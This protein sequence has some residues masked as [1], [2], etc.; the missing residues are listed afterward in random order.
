[1]GAAFEGLFADPEAPTDPAIAVDAIA[2]IVAMAPGTR[3]FRT[4][5]G[6]DFGVRD[7]NAALE[8][9]DAGLL[10]AL[11]MTSFAT[12]APAIDGSDGAVT[13]VFDQT[14]TSSTTFA[15]TFAASGAVSDSG[16]TEDALTITSD[17]G[18][19][20]LVGTFR[21]TV[22]GEKGTFVLTGD[23]TVDLSDLAAANVNGSWR[24]ELATG[25]YAGHTG[26]CAVSGAADLTL[27][28]PRGSVRYA[29]QLR[30]IQETTR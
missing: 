27:P 6:V 3:P 13:F 20:P 11:G 1:M 25:A 17:E 24:V 29:G 5:L 15:G 2:E 8:P 28:R 18:A 23:V 7:R 9:L 12:L 19:S 30:G 4:C 26:E 14:A 22:T 21:R 16:T 10:E